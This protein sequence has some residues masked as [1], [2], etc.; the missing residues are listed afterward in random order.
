V[1]AD[2]GGGEDGD[3]RGTPGVGVHVDEAFEAD[4]EAAFLAGLANS[5]RFERLAP[6]DVPTGK[7]PPAV[8]R[9]DSPAHKDESVIG[10]SDDGADGNLG[11]QI[12]HEP[13]P[14]AHRPLG[15]GRLQEPPFERAATARTEA[16]SV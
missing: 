3:D 15:L 9:L 16:V 14:R 10:S 12:E 4:L 13:A 7:H 2:W 1:A 8:A 5:G 6:I 11:V